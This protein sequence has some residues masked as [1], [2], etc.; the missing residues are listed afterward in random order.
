[1]IAKREL[2]QWAFSAS[3]NVCCSNLFT[4]DKIRANVETTPNRLNY[5]LYCST[6]PKSI[7]ACFLKL[8]DCIFG[9]EVRIYIHRVRKT[10]FILC[11]CLFVVWWIKIDIEIIPKMI[12]MNTTMWHTVYCVCL[13]VKMSILV[14]FERK[15]YCA[16]L[17]FV[18]FI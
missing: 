10:I 16:Q 3:W 1:M 15:S 2:H 5:L 9:L 13:C 6:R 18:V 14:P 7:I 12:R 4:A 11:F 8:I 17:Q